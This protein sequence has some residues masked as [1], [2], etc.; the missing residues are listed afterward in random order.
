MKHLVACSTLTACA[1]AHAQ[2]G[3]TLYGA[4][5]SA[6]TYTTNQG[7]K[8]SLQAYSGG[9]A[10][11]KIGVRGVEDLGGGLKAVFVLEAGFNIETG[12]SQPANTLFGRQAFVGLNSSWGNVYLGRQYSMT[13]DYFVPLSTS[14]LFAGGLGATLGDIDD[15]WNYNKISNVI[16]YE[17]P[18]YGHFHYS[19][20][21]S[22]GE[23][24]GDSSHDRTYGTGVQYVNENL[25]VAA[26]YMKIQTPATAIFGASSSPV[27]AADFV[28]P[29][30]NPIFQNY[31]T[32]NS[33]QVL[34]GGA[35]YV[36]GRS[37]WSLLYSNVRFNDVVRTASNR[38]APKNAVFNNLQLNYTYS[39]TPSTLGGI[40][41]QYNTSPGGHYNSAEAG[42]AY[43]FSKSTYVY[44]VAVWQH[45]SGRD[46]SGNRAVA[47]L[48]GLSPSSGPNQLAVRMGLRKTF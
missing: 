37:Q 24:P 32:A 5:D 3:V 21:L 41:W 45:A 1:L 8:T 47:N 11:D 4:V 33:Q 26:A 19:V 48:F 39:F 6:I 9:R 7:G 38:M 27:A 15:S 17:S 31:V 23:K 10:G 13:N 25:N 44:G 35:K 18:T 22:L 46:S 12:A 40:G 20:M 2:N 14:F 34:G 42:T 16:K 36:F 30:K 29:I 28:N 43:Y